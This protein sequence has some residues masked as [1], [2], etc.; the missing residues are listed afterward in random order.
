MEKKGLNYQ[1][2]CAGSRVRSWRRRH[3][4][5]MGAFG[6]RRIAGSKK[7]KMKIVVYA[8]TLQALESEDS[9]VNNYVGPL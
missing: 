9:N 2:E 8:K 4:W 7:K 1:G 6:E 3:W 5:K